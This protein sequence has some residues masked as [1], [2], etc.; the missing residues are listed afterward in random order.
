MEYEVCLSMAFLNEM[1]PLYQT[2]LFK[3]SAQAMLAWTLLVTT[4]ETVLP[5]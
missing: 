3:N 1:L 4:L 5:H 2:M